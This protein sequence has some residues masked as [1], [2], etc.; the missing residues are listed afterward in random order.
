MA[1]SP[2]VFPALPSPPLLTAGMTKTWRLVALLL[3]LLVLCMP[4]ALAFPVAPAT[5]QSASTTVRSEEDDTTDEEADIFWET[6]HISRTA[7]IAIIMCVI[8]A[9]LAFT[10]FAIYYFC[11][12]VR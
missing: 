7:L 8:V 5:A 1:L 9:M 3:L 6:F 10:C 11:G 2:S 12:F 4:F